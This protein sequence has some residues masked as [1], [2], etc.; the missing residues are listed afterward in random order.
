M[1]ATLKLIFSQGL[2]GLD[3]NWPAL[4][5]PEPGHMIKWR[6]VIGGDRTGILGPKQQVAWAVIQPDRCNVIGA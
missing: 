5:G 4:I 2:V 3:Q 1:A 6:S